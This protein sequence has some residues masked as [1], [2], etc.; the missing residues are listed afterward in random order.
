M[1][2]GTVL[3]AS[4]SPIGRQ[5]ETSGSSVPA[6]PA[7][8]AVNRRLITLT[9]WVE[10]MPT[11]LSSTTQPWT[12]RLSRLNCL[13]GL[14]RGGS[15]CSAPSGAAKSA[16]VASTILFIAILILGQVAL[17]FRLTQQLLDAL[18]FREAVI[19]AEPQ[20]RCKFEVYGVSDLAAQE[21]LVALE[22]GDHLV[23]VAAGKR[24]DVDGGQP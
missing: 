3:V 17:H 1:T 4:P 23:S 16:S 8:L 22:G 21:S 7:R 19:D 12:S 20:I 6:W 9:A 15:A 13:C 11:G 24:H 5:P 18:D 14:A 10:V 2:K